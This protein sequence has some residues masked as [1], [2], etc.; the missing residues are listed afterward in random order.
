MDINLPIG[1]Y[2]PQDD[3]K[4]IDAMYVPYLK[5]KVSIQENKKIKKPNDWSTPQENQTNDKDTCYIDVNTWQNMGNPNMVHNDQYKIGWD[6][7]FQKI[8]PWNPCP[9]GW[10]DRGN[11]I[12]DRAND[13]SY[14]SEFYTKDQFAVQYQ[15]RNGYTVDLRQKQNR[16]NLTSKYGQ[17]QM[18][19]KAASVNPFTG[20]YVVYH[21]PKPSKSTVKYGG[22]PS[23]HSYL[24]I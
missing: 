23:R 10:V 17:E 16:D 5:T 22:L 20:N 13:E 15:Y 7:T 2:Y 6:Q 4:Y 11:G 21:E 24:G 12:C 18:P 9:G 14:Q 3:S 1:G 8:Y 19:M